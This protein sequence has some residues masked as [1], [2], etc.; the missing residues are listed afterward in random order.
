VPA[1]VVSPL[2]AS[3]G[4]LSA[5]HAHTSWQHPKTTA[6]YSERFKEREVKPGDIRPDASRRGFDRG[7]AQ[8]PFFPRQG[9][10]YSCERNRLF[11]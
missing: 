1:V 7:T 8:R 5:L 2:D 11:A 9:S 10:L 6:K 3:S 4:A